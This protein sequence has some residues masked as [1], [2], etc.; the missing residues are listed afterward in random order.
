MNIPNFVEAQYRRLNNAIDLEYKEL[1]EQISDSTLREI[2]STLHSRFIYL[3][4]RMNERLPTHDYSAHYWA[5][6]S[7]DLL[8]AIEISQSLSKSLKGT[9]LAI[10]IDEYYKG[11]FEQCLDFLCKSGGSTIPEGMDKIELYYKIPIFTSVNTI[12]KSSGT[13]D[14]H[15]PLK[16][17]GEGSYAIVY[18]Y[19]DDY[20]NRYFVIKRAKKDL[21][22]KEL[23]RFKQEYEEMNKLKSPYIVEVFR[24]DGN[25]NEYIMEHMDYTLND[26]ISKNNGELTLQKRK[27]FVLQVLKAFD[28]LHSKERLHRDISPKNILIKEYDDISVLKVSDFGLVKIPDSSLTSM[29]TELKG[30]F[31][32]PALVVEGFSNYNIFHETYAL[33]RLIFYIMTGR[34]NIG[35][36]SNKAVQSFMGKGLN[37]NKELRFQNI[38]ELQI[39]FLKIASYPWN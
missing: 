6:E 29:N 12:T 25:K 32:D 30:Y 3:F 24:Y 33:T 27:G 8:D 34:T 22:D 11:V 18:R 26:Y 9:A 10:D 2:I 37:A 19:M 1:Y 38:Q 35:K 31:N 13:L 15:Y 14:S 36:I 20:Y 21:T 28:Y 17:I 16:M 7:R 5:S 23:Q 39:D 4:R